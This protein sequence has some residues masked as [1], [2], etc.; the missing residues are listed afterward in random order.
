MSTDNIL[1]A[2][3]FLTFMFSLMN[4]DKISLRIKSEKEIKDY[5]INSYFIYMIISLI[6]FF[7]YGFSII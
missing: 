5:C 4:L 2:F 6:V 3:T 7:I 1:L